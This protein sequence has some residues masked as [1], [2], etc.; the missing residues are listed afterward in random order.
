MNLK[1]TKTTFRCS[2]CREAITI[3]STAF[4][5]AF[6]KCRSYQRKR[7]KKAVFEYGNI[8]IRFFDLDAIYFDGGERPLFVG[9]GVEVAPT[10]AQGDRY[11]VTLAGEKFY[12]LRLVSFS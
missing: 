8:T 2:R 7:I 3:T 10:P 12:G 5:M 11:T 9:E 6:C 1:T 4:C